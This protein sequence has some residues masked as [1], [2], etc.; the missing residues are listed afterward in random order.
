MSKSISD[1]ALYAFI[2]EL[3]SKI[4]SRGDEPFRDVA[5][6]II[7]ECERSIA[8]PDVRTFH[9]VVSS[10]GKVLRDWNCLNSDKPPAVKKF[11]RQY[12]E[13]RVYRVEFGRAEYLDGE[14]EDISRNFERV[15]YLDYDGKIGW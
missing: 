8:Q 11:V 4:A 5:A 15:A 14:Y 1:I 10:T 13:C 9:R 7:A 2:Y 3:K 6:D 12:P